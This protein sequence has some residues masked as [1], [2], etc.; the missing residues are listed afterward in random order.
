MILTDH[1]I[2]KLIKD[3]NLIEDFNEKSL[4]PNGYDLRVGT[5]SREKTKDFNILRVSTLE[6]LHMPKN[7]SGL[8]F[9]KSKWCR[10]GLFASV[11]AVDAGFQ[12][13]LTINL[14][15]TSPVDIQN[16][17]ML[18]QILFCEQ[19]SESNKD[20]NTRSGNFHQSKGIVLEKLNKK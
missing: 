14:L 7:I 20:Y 6:Y 5:F 10:K 11:G 4:T 17:D 3:S 18:I 15:E 9:L 13:N 2:M 16:G 19:T 12:G 8:L 1:D